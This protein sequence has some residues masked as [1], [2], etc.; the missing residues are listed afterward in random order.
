MNRKILKANQ[1]KAH[2][3]QLFFLVHMKKSNKNNLYLQNKINKII[4]YSHLH[5]LKQLKIL[6][7]INQKFF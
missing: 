1:N 7:L 3:E 5:I 4:I 2:Q 6:L